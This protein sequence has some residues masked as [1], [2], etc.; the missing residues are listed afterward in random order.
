MAASVLQLIGFLLPA[1]GQILITA[2]T[3]MDMWSVQDRSFT[4]VTHVYTYSGLWK[5]CVGT[6]YGAAQCRPY[7][8]ILG[9]PGEKIRWWEKEAFYQA[10]LH[11]LD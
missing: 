6:A 5:S 2:A 10:G 9:L 11:T 7:F 1:L 3:A 8:T 4:L